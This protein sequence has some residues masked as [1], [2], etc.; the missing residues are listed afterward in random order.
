MS[1]RT[2]NTECIHTTDA[3]VPVNV[4]TRKVSEE[5]HAPSLVTPDRPLVRRKCQEDRAEPSKNGWNLM[6]QIHFI[7][8]DNLKI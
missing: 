8:R 6:K 4:I 7:I 2:G 1:G 3:G 5:R